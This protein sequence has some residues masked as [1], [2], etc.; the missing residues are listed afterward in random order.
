[1]PVYLE[2]AL[3]AG[4]KSSYPLVSSWNKAALEADIG[5]EVHPVHWWYL[6][7]RPWHWRHSPAFMVCS[8]LHA[9]FVTKIPSQGCRWGWAASVAFMMSSVVRMVANQHLKAASGSRR[10]TSSHW[11][12]AGTTHSP[13]S[14]VRFAFW[15]RISAFAI[16]ACDHLLDSPTPTRAQSKN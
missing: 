8:S 13:P 6:G 3:A 7:P 5:H 4:P 12:G 10:L 9:P 14:A 2:H 1:M 16:L 11:A 15:C